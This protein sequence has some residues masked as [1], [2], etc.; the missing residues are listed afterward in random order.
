MRGT[1][2]LPLALA[3]ACSS[4]TSPERKQLSGIWRATSATLATGVSA[5]QINLVQ[6]NDTIAGTA[7]LDFI[8]DRPS[9]ELQI[10]GKAGLDGSTACFPEAPIGTCHVNFRFTAADAGGDTLFFQGQFLSGNLLTGDV[11][12]SSGLPFWNVDG[13]MLQFAR[14]AALN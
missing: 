14:V 12:S 6:V 9:L 11:Q 10:R 4:S 1:L 7:V 13:R 3:I 2:V 5:L 8:G